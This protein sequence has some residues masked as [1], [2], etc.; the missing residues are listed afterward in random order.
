MLLLAFRPGWIT[1]LRLVG[2]GG[3]VALTNYMLQEAL[4]DV[5]GSTFVLL[6]PA[7]FFAQAQLS[8]AWLARQLFGPLEWLWR[9]ITYAKLQ[10]LRRE[11]IAV[12]TGVVSAI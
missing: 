9:C 7:M 2:S 4:F 5:L 12:A 8:R 6:A 3:R 11:Q 10:P 1:R